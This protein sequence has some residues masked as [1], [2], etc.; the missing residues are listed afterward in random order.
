[1]GRPQL[2]RVHYQPLNP[3]LN[4]DTFPRRSALHTGTPGLDLLL[5]TPPSP[6]LPEEPCHVRHQP[7]HRRDEPPT[8]HEPCGRRRGPRRPCDGVYQLDPRQRRR[9]E[10]AAQGGHPPLDGGRPE[11]H[12]YLGSEAGGSDRRPLQADLHECR[13]DPDLRAHAA[14]VA[15]DASHVARPFDEHAGSGPHAR[16]L[17]HAHRLRA[18][19]QCRAPELRRRDRPRAGRSGPRSGD[20]PVRFG[21]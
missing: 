16:P 2:Q 1:M 21:R 10:A 15:A 4:P 5:P 14:D 17:L 7:F 19:S 12:G 8:L 13:W 9:S 18:E 3:A 6:I 11:H 20:P